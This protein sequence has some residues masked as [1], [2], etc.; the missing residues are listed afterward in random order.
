MNSRSDAGDAGATNG[1]GVPRVREYRGRRRLPH[2]AGQGNRVF[3]DLVG[4]YDHVM[5]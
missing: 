3:G 4:Q 5:E 2:L 1:A